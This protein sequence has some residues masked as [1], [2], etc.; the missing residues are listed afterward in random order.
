MRSFPADDVDV[1]ALLSEL[2]EFNQVKS[3]EHK[4]RKFGVIR[5]FVKYQRPKS[6]N[7]VHFMPPDL[8][9]YAGYEDD[10]SEPLPNNSGNLPAEEGGRRKEVNSTDDFF[11]TF[12]KIYPPR[13]PHQNPKKPAKL[14][15][16]AAVKRGVDPQTI[17]DGATRYAAYV[18]SEETDPQFI[19]QAVTWL[20][21]EC[22]DAVI[23]I[24][25][26]AKY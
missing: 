2:E 20:N 6:P 22:W 1:E 12:W 16:A 7:F 18:D 5:N 21:Q 19:K 8:R 4:G 3:Y 11:E 23:E 15:F 25:K 17:I 14:K 26:K 13:L 10:I 24:K 9:N